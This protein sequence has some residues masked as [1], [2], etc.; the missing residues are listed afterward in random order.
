MIEDITLA[1]FTLSNSLRVVT[2]VPQIARAARTE[3]G[4]KPFRL[5]HGVCS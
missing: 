4:Q 1:A 5:G 3:V 2:Y